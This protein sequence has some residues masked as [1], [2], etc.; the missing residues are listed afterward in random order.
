M[1]LWT[2]TGK[3]VVNGKNSFCYVAETHGGMS[4]GPVWKYLN[5]NRKLEYDDG[6]PMVLGNH[7]MGPCI[8]TDDLKACCRLTA[9]KLNRIKVIIDATKTIKSH[10]FQEYS[11]FRLLLLEAQKASDINKKQRALNKIINDSDGMMLSEKAEAHLML[12]TIYEADAYGFFQAVHHLKEAQ[13]S[14][15]SWFAREAS[16]RLVQIYMRDN[17][18][19]EALAQFDKADRG[20]ER[21]TEVRIEALISYGKT[22]I[23]LFREGN[24]CDKKSEILTKARS[25]VEE[26]LR[27]CKF[28]K[29]MEML[30]E[31]N[32]I[33]H[34]VLWV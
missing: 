17:S 30:I 1:E 14:P 28:A 31:L 13:K 26:A 7:I 23:K 34:I 27:I 19:M 18:L 4:G 11:G 3:P 2:V 33:Q 12:A 10:E 21:Y 8:A 16:L 6:M 32:A 29:R 22:A 15:F 20:L 24:L 5:L 25:K 9:A